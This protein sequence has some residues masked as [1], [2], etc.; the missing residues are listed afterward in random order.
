MRSGTDLQRIARELKKMFCLK[1][2]NTDYNAL[3]SLASIITLRRSVSMWLAIGLPNLR[4]RASVPGAG[5]VY[6]ASV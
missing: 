6:E 5:E 3:L 1:K 2:L 4:S